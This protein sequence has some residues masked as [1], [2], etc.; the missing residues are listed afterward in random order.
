M[1]EIGGGAFQRQPAQFHDQP[2]FFRMGDEIGGRDQA[3]GRMPPAQQRLETGHA[4]V[5]KPDDG[6]VEH[7]QMASGQRMTKLAF[8]RHTVAAGASVSSSEE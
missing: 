8:Q 4:A 6:L 2:G 1:G 5:R 3:L 7:V